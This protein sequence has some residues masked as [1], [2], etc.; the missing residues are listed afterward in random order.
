MR[1]PSRLDFLPINYCIPLQRHTCHKCCFLFVVHSFL[2]QVQLFE[3]WPFHITWKMTQLE[4]C[5]T[6]P[7][8]CFETVNDVCTFL[9]IHMYNFTDHL[10]TSTFVEHF[11]RNCFALVS[12]RRYV[13]LSCSVYHQSQTCGK[14]HNVYYTT[15][16]QTKPL[17][18][19]WNV[20]AISLCV[21]IIFTWTCWITPTPHTVYCKNKYS[22]K[23]TLPSS[24][25]KPQ[26]C[27]L[28]RNIQTKC[29]LILGKRRGRRMKYPVMSHEMGLPIFIYT[30]LICRI[31]LSGP[32]NG[33]LSNHS[34][35]SLFYVVEPMQRTIVR[36]IIYSLLKMNVK[37]ITKVF[38]VNRFEQHPSSKTDF[39]NFVAFE[40][41]NNNNGPSFSAPVHLMASSL[42]PVRS[43]RPQLQ[44]CA[45]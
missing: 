12:G 8:N 10:S 41:P 38:N 31:L 34:T 23:Y 29:T 4:Q 19:M 32:F 30:S 6:V 11:E 36:L 3:L 35:R 24:P 44:S 40:C 42:R 28:P 43:V 33:L 21:C 39:T 7:E 18:F 26:A 14:I 15:N 16:K 20:L 27:E 13:H 1:L 17:H 22:E 37:N 5:F 2:M 9:L 25:Q 45:G